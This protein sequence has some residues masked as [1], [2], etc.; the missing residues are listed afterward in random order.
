MVLSRATA[1]R[2]ITQHYLQD[3]ANLRAANEKKRQKRSRSNRKIPCEEGLTVDEGLQLVE[4]RN[5]P[6]EGDEI[7]SHMQGELPSQPI[8]PPTR[9]PPR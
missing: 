2:Y 1:K 9:A 5:Q 3:N 8:L 4:Q 6:V 7:E